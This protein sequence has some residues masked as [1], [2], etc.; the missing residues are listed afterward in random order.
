M[1]KQSKSRM[2]DSSGTP[3]SLCPPI[4]CGRETLYIVQ[5]P[6][7]AYFFC[8]ECKKEPTARPNTS[9]TQKSINKTKSVGW[10]VPTLRS[11]PFFNSNSIVELPPKT[12]RSR[13]Q[14]PG[15]YQLQFHADRIEAVKLDDKDLAYVSRWFE[16]SSHGYFSGTTHE[17]VKYRTI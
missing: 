16:V 6:S 15:K 14:S 8:K 1:A 7:L 13:F 2:T 17:D 10:G 4:C 3:L 12:L 11:Y 9:Q 5:S